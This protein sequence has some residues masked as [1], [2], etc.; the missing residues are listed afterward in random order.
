[1]HKCIV[2]YIIYVY[3]GEIRVHEHESMSQTALR[4]DWC[5]NIFGFCLLIQEQH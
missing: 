5:N 2:S 4:L 1:M 3:K